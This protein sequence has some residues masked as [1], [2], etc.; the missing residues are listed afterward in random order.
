MD[1]V[2]AVGRAIRKAEDKGL[3][4]VV[5]P[6]LV[7]DA[8]LAEEVLESSEFDRVWEVVRALRTHDDD[9]ADEL[10]ALRREQGRRGSVKGHPRKIML[11]LPVGVGAA[12]ARAFDSKVVETSTASWEFWFGLLER[13]VAEHGHSRVP[14]AHVTDDGV[15]ARTVGQR[16]APFPQVQHALEG[17]SR[18]A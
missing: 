5:I 10:D 17:E 15:Q 8:A 16:S 7:T 1:V 13:Y 2:Q 18:A 4:T 6:V 14:A 11:D 12:F 3:G 9:L